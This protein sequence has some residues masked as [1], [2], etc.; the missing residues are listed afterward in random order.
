[1][2]TAA[3]T[4]RSSHAPGRASNNSR[5]IATESSTQPRLAETRANFMT[6]PRTSLSRP[7][8]PSP[9]QPKEESSCLFLSLWLVKARV[10][11][12]SY[13]SLCRLRFRRCACSGS[14][15]C[16]TLVISTA[17]L[18]VAFVN[19]RALEKTERSEAGDQ[20]RFTSGTVFGS[21]TSSCWRQP[22]S[23][24]SHLSFWFQATSPC[25]SPSFWL[26]AASRCHSVALGRWPRTSRLQ[27]PAAS[28]Q[29]APTPS[30]A[31]SSP[32]LP[33]DW[34]LELRPI[35]QIRGSGVLELRRF[36]QIRARALMRKWR[37][38]AQVNQQP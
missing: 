13:T 4:R 20:P 14:G 18:R 8:A 26:H 15:C 19:T 25:H 7:T 36:R 16:N 21:R 17:A 9:P 37:L 28:D 30:H 35:N 11:I 2:R 34:I 10:S 12:S 38:T 3:R 23:P 29:Q 6:T 33:T 5:H 22:A 27:R 1:M 32:H 24:C 31:L